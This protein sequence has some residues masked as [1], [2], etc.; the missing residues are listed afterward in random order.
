MAVAFWCLLVVVLMPPTFAAIAK[1]TAEGRYNNRSPREFLEHQSGLSRRADWAQRNSFEILPAF[2][3]GVFAA[4]AAGV[5]EQWL[6]RLSLIFVATRI[7]YGICYLKDWAAARSLCWFS[8]FFC[9]LGLL[10]MAALAAA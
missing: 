3:A 1:A 4:I 9:C 2:I 10:V 7:L 6:A 5:D 8:G